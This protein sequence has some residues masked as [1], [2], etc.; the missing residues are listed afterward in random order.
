MS[1]EK[2]KATAEDI[3]SAQG[4]SE[5][6]QKYLRTALQ[7]FFEGGTIRDVKGLSDDE[8][9]ALYSVGYN[10]FQSG[11]YDDAEKVLRYLAMIDHTN[12]KY[13][14]ALGVLLQT[15]RKFE[16]AAACYGFAGFLD[17]S[18]PEPQFYAA[19]CFLALGDRESAKSALAALEEFA[20]KDSVYREKAKK[21]AARLVA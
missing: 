15:V 12:A 9:E 13:W 7:H 5:E 10:L 11:K 3:E 21:L 14:L 1:D 20:P 6:Q 8:M 4:M 2:I 19:E 16:Q 17:L 18:N